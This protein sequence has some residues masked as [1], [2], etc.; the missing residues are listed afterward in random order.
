M[1]EL[2]FSGVALGAA[3]V[4]W[5]CLQARRREQRVMAALAQGDLGY[6][7]AGSWR[8]QL[9]AWLQSGPVRPRPCTATVCNARCQSLP[10]RNSGVVT[11]VDAGVYRGAPESF[12]SLSIELER[13]GDDEPEVELASLLDELDESD[14]LQSGRVYNPRAEEPNDDDGEHTAWSA[15]T[16]PRAVD[17]PLRAMRKRLYSN[18]AFVPEYALFTGE[19]EETAPRL[20]V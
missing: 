7:S 12:A 13:S 9:I 3:L 15:P 18:G 17:N 16:L 11:R 2:A 5:W 6:L 10:R 20:V 4:V 19:S 8:D 14:T 1:E